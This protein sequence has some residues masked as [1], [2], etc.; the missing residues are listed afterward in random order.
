MAV[1]ITQ[2]GF[3]WQDVWKSEH[4]AGFTVAKAMDLD[5]LADIRSAVD[6]ALAE[7][8]FAALLDGA[9]GGG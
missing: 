1:T 7:G 3:S 4:A 8:S 6:Q 9:A 2:L 5:L